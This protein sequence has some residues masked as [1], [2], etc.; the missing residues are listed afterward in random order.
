MD[1]KKILSLNIL[2]NYPEDI[3]NITPMEENLYLHKSARDKF[4]EDF[5]FKGKLLEIGPLNNPFLK[6]RF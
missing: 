5:D 4:K 2:K 6:K 1:L 3:K